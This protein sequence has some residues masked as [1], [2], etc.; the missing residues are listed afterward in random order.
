MEG[1]S[2]EPMAPQ[3]Q[4]HTQSRVL[5]PGNALHSKCKNCG[6]SGVTS[7]KE[8]A[9][10]RKN[11]PQFMPNLQSLSICGYGDLQWGADRKWPEDP[12]PLSAPSLTHL[13]LENL[14]LYPSFLCLK[15]L[16]HFTLAD[17]KFNLH[18]DVLLDFLEGNN[19]LEFASLSIQFA[20]PLL[21][22]SHRPALVK[23]RLRH[24]SASGYVTDIN[25]LTSKIEVQK[26]GNV[27]ISLCEWNTGLDDISSVV[28]TARILNRLSSTSMEYYADAR[29]ARTMRLLG[30]NGSFS[31]E[32][33]PGAETLS[34]SS[35]CS[36]F[37]TFE[38]FIFCTPYP[39]LTHSVTHL[40]CSLFHSSPP[41]IHLR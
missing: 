3:R 25:A 33:W 41:S 23:N 40:Q 31:L 15:T 12:R 2:F 27:G 4:H 35:L 9:L 38:I 1:G 19:S 39:I 13:S 26:G 8:L 20:Q 10:I 34:W 32:H 29:G 6:P 7:S 17:S 11:F 14:H 36:L 37:I 21:R 18:L 5:W 16:T 28:Y 24:L 30:L 22:H